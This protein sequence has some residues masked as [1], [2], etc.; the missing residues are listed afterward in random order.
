MGPHE[1]P[2]TSEQLQRL[3]LVRKC[4]KETL[5]L[6]PLLHITSREVT[7]DSVIL[8]YQIPAGVFNQSLLSRDPRYFKDPL[9]FDLDCWSHDVDQI[10]PFAS[11]LFG[12]GPRMCYG[13]RIAELELVHVVLTRILQEFKLSTDQQA[14]KPSVF[15]VLQ[16]NEPVRIKFSD[17]KE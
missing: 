9:K 7:T 16:P 15:I 5:Q 12:F 3:G 17:C 6:Y 14:I 8:G 13:R 2:P 11:L 10:H 1:N 4:V